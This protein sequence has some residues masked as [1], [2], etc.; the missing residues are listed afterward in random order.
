MKKP[1]LFLAGLP[2]SGTSSMHAY[3]KQHPDIFMTAIKEPNYFA[4][5]FH[6]ESDDYHNKQLYFPY[7]TKDQYL[8]LY[9][10]WNNEKI[11]GEASWTNLYSKI[12]AKGIHQFNPNAKIIIALRE[13]VSFLYSYHSAATFALGESIQDFKKA[14]SAEV[15]RKNGKYL[16]KRVIAPS[17]LFYSEFV[18][19]ADHVQ[20]YLSL[21]NNDQIRIILFDELKQN[22]AGVYNIILKFLDVPSDFSPE[23]NIVNPNKILKWPR[24]KKLIL[25]SP[26]FRNTLRFFISDNTYANLKKLYKDRIVTYKARLPLNEDIKNEL[27][28]NFKSEVEKLSRL[29]NR[30]LIAL[31]GYDKIG[32]R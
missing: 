22:T 10:S 7:R 20:R 26:Y 3:L 15:E 29:L 17:W 30:D 18:K 32:F 12:A 24:L 5:D 14:L 28:A 16:G 23:F 21:F 25:D 1:N 6:K 11:A 31:W 8:R 27:M 2:R 9:K 13:P 19:Y 4:R